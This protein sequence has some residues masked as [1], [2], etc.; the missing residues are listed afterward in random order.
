M[1]RNN[2]VDSND[3]LKNVGARAAV[4]LARDVKQSRCMREKKKT[5]FIIVRASFSK[6]EILFIAFHILTRAALN[7]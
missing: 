7:D 3:E 4:L 1:K 2:I 5:Q 6:K